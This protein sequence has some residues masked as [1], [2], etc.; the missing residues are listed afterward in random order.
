MVCNDLVMPV[1]LRLRALR[2]GRAPGLTGAAARH[3]PR[4]DHRDAAARLPLFPCWPA[5]R[6]RWS[7]IG[8]ISFAA[9]AQFAPARP[10]RHL[11]EGR[12]A[13]RR[14]RRA[15]CRLRASGS[16]R[17]CCRRSR[18]SGWLPHRAS[19]THGPFGIAL[20][21]PYALF[22]LDGLERITH[23]M[24]WSM[25]A[26]VGALR[27]RV[28]CSRRQS[29]AEQ[30]QAALFVD[31]F[32]HEGDGRG[33]AAGAARASVPRLQALLARF[34]G[35]GARGRALRRL[36][37]A[38]RR[39]RP[40]GDARRRRGARAVRRD[41]A[42]GRHRRRLG[43]RSWSPRWCRRSRSRSTRC[44]TMLD[45]ASQV[46]AYSH[47]LEAEVAG[48][49]GGDRRAARRQRAAEGARPAE[50]RLH[51]DGDAR[52]AHAAHVDP[53]LLRDPARQPRPR[54]GRA[55]ATSSASSSRRRERLTRLINQVLD[56]AKLESGRAEWQV[57]AVDLA[58]SSTDA[59]DATSQL[60]QRARRRASS[61]G[62]RRACR[63]VM[64][65]RDRAGAGAAQPAVER[66]QVLPAGARPRRRR[67]SPSAGGGC[68]RGRAATTAR[69]SAPS[70]SR[71]SSR[72]S[73]RPATRS[74]R[75]PRAPGSACR[76]AAR[77]SSISAAG[78]G[79]RASRGGARRSRSRCRSPRAARR[80]RAP[81][82]A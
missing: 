10:R 42:R 15:R 13:R 43:A 30:A 65:D 61:R 24:L 55:P 36:R 67:G 66:G 28:R 72:S 39:A 22:G 57:A 37:A 70:T 38:A 77:S 44:M 73:A 34:L 19:S 58:A 75:S 33:A 21:R 80:A 53:R 78:C 25:I 26:N 14:A 71:S 54:R 81:R 7:A 49:G 51:L 27:R 20:L 50:G 46:I 31:V 18:K 35:A 6:T 4:R 62:C 60:F 68:A 40:A 76:S 82:R 59:V 56:L 48:A 69:A 8:L 74:R 5:R 2:L 3:P 9:V 12:H 32:R 64:A 17:C 79:S 11:L 41:A 63:R 23:A 47:E 16:T 1:L 52:A 45:E 29:V